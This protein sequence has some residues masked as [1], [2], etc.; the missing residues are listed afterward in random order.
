[1]LFILFSC[2]GWDLQYNVNISGECGDLCLIPNLKEKTFRFSPLKMMPAVGFC[3][4]SLSGHLINAVSITESKVLVPNNKVILLK[5][6][7]NFGIWS[8][9]TEEK[10]PFSQTKPGNHYSD[11]WSHVSLV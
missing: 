6:T 2:T 3:R 4:C 7:Y 5:H 10:T 8:N 11:R 9:K 1:M